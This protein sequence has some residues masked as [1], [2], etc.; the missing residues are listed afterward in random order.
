M[1]QA[2]AVVKAVAEAEIV[3]GLLSDGQPF[4]LTQLLRA[5]LA[6]TKLPPLGRLFAAGCA[7][8]RRRSEEALANAVHN[9]RRGV[10]SASFRSVTSSLRQ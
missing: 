5:F 9:R 3:Q 4:T 6:T 2:A 10:R 7:V 1:D 8:V